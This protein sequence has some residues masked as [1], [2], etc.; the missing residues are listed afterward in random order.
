M[1]VLE[2]S[3]QKTSY[4]SFNDTFSKRFQKD[5]ENLQTFIVHDNNKFPVK[6]NLIENDFDIHL[7]FEN[8]PT[9]FREKWIVF[10]Y[11]SQGIVRSSY[12][13]LESAPLPTMLDFLRILDAYKFP[14]KGEFQFRYSFNELLSFMIDYLRDYISNYSNQKVSIRF[15]KEENCIYITNSITLTSIQLHLFDGGYWLIPSIPKPESAQYELCVAI[16]KLCNQYELLSV[17]GVKK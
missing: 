5:G 12:F 14:F 11:K 10:P 1:K 8:T 4:F 2:L 6:L 16:E 3:I 9:H 13:L 7:T 15:S 17:F